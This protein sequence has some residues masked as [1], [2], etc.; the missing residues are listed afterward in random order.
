MEY[1]GIFETVYSKKLFEELCNDGEHSRYFNEQ[2]F[3]RWLL[4]GSFEKKE[5]P[6]TIL[7]MLEF[8]NDD[9]FYSVEG[10]IIP[11][12]VMMVRWTNIE[13]DDF[14]DLELEIF[15]HP[16]TKLW[17]ARNFDMTIYSAIDMENEMFWQ[18]LGKFFPLDIKEPAF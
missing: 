17:L 7:E 13:T 5:T 6:G 12:R 11:C 2:D 9:C 3:I 10:T 18:E 4:V 1:H 14:I 15:Q 16:E 8:G